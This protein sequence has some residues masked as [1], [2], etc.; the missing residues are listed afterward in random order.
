MKQIKIG[1]R[2]FREGDRVIQMRNNYVLG[3]YNGD[4]GKIKS[5]DLENYQ[6]QVQ[7]G[8]QALVDYKKDDLT[9][10]ALAYGITIHKSQGE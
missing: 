9:E 1:D 4:I 6:C 5:I 3:I 8:K 7:F 2:I 10:I